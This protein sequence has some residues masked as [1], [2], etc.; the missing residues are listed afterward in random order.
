[1][2]LSFFVSNIITVL[3]S[4]MDSFTVS[5]TMDEAA[6][7]AVGFVSP[8]VILFSL[9]GTTASVGFLIMCIRYLSRGDKESA[10][11]ALG[12]S[13]AVLH[14]QGRVCED[15]VS[16]VAGGFYWRTVRFQ[17]GIIVIIYNILP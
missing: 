16:Y 12:E 4:M 11:K 8:A 14:G 10:G 5:N 7:A 17:T 2:V 3:G 15:R 1:M 13:V 6:V 9:I